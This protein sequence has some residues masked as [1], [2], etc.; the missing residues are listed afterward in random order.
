M[1]DMIYA[2]KT[3]CKQLDTKL[4]LACQSYLGLYADDE[5]DYLDDE[6]DKAMSDYEKGEYINRFSMGFGLSSK[7]F[8]FIP[9]HL[10]LDYAYSDL[11]LLGWVPRL[12]IKI[13]F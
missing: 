7:N 12:T 4:E 3:L 13:N 8:P 6:S 2:T 1:I 10:N 5:S 11:G 9:Y